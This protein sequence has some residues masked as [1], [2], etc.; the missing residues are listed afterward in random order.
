M[1]MWAL[2]K[3]SFQLH[4]IVCKLLL[5]AVCN[6]EMEYFTRYFRAGLFVKTNR[7]LCKNENSFNK[8]T[9]ILTSNLVLVLL[10][11]LCKNLHFDYICLVLLFDSWIKKY[12]FQ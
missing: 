4:W 2:Y 1:E 8:F 10:A 9:D 3:R 6:H 5:K 11:F 12:F 7:F